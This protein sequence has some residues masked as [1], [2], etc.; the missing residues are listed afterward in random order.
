MT[1]EKAKKNR[2]LVL[3]PVFNSNLA[4]FIHDPE[5]NRMG[6][7]RFERF[8]ASG[9]YLLMGTIAGYIFFVGLENGTASGYHYPTQQKLLIGAALTGAATL[10]LSAILIH[11][12]LSAAYGI[13][14]VSTLL[15]WLA[16]WPFLVIISKELIIHRTLVSPSCSD[17][18]ALSPLP[19]ATV[20]SILGLL[21]V[22]RG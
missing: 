10:L 15:L 13:A 14:S 19:L 1:R 18:L 16:F 4:S 5:D 12:R 8:L 6:S 20:F 7:Q 21:R 2:K 11:F 22:V 17:L 3:T 9:I